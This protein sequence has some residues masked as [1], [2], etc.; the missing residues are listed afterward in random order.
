MPTRVMAG[1]PA[2]P[3]SF[4]SFGRWRC[5]PAV[6]RFSSRRRLSWL[7]RGAACVCDCDCAA[8]VAGPR[9]PQ[10]LLADVRRRSAR[11]RRPRG[12]AAGARPRAR[13]RI[14]RP[15]SQAA[16]AVEPRVRVAGRSRPAACG[17]QMSPRMLARRAQAVA[18]RARETGART[19]GTTPPPGPMTRPWLLLHERLVAR[20]GA[21][22][23][24][25]QRHL[26]RSS[27]A[28]SSR[29]PCVWWCMSRMRAVWPSALEH[30][31]QP[32][33]AHR[34][35][36]CSMVLRTRPSMSWV[37]VRTRR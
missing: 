24:Q 16:S 28:R 2:W 35:S 3:A 29:R 8:V 30:R 33:E 20:A 25:P 4:S 6:L 14:A 5:W 31:A 37:P 17:G 10:H 19:A 1:G 26:A 9:R 32:Q 23:R 15:S 36:S 34:A 27:C 22:Q 18:Q 13:R 12:S 21:Q 7:L 11:S